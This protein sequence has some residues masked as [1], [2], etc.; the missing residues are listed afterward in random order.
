MSKDLGLFKKVD[1]RRVWGNEAAEFT[2]W[3]AKEENMALL[4][5]ALGLEL[6]VENIEVA[7]GPYS[8]DILAKDTG[9]GKYV[10]IENQLGKTNHDHLGKSITY[11]SA[12]DASAIVWIAGE[13]TDEHQRAFDWLNDRTSEDLAFYAVMLEVWQIDDSRPAVRFN[14]LSRPPQAMRKIAILKASGELTEARKLQLD[15]WTEFRNKLLAAKVVPSAR[16][17]LPQ[18]WFDIPLG[19]TGIHISNIADTSGNKVGTRIYLI[20]KVADAALEKLLQEKNQIEQQI[21]ATLL[22]NPNPDN[23]DKTIA[24]YH[25]ADLKNRE[26]WPEYI[27]WLVDMSKRF[28]NAFMPRVKILKFETIIPESEG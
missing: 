7:V 22:W 19:R 25:D 18:Y 16:T 26:K 5:Q 2:P 6:E 4:G 28:R 15:F 23:R 11:G 20:S 10:V 9:T 12:L 21:G 14:I 3:L 24:I 13:F 1:I 27:D 8:A 17:P